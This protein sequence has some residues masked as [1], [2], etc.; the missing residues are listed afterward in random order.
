MTS[1]IKI[2]KILPVFAIRLLLSIILL[3]SLSFRHSIKP[4]I[5]SDPVMTEAGLVSG[6]KSETSNI[7]AYK[8][9]PFAAPPIGELRWKAPQPAIPWQGVRKCESFGPSPMQAKPVPFMVYTSSF[10]YLKNPLVKTVFI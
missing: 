1:K 7:I 3:L 2:L 8:G 4:V 5:Y 10:S 9:I 6:V